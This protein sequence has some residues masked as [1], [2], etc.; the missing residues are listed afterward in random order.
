MLKQQLES[1]EVHLGS[2]R[3]MTACPK[4]RKSYQL[5]TLKKT[6]VNWVPHWILH[7]HQMS[8]QLKLYQLLLLQEYTMRLEWVYGL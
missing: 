8:K 3:Q 6:Y 2:S 7:K 1:L 5:D 4:S